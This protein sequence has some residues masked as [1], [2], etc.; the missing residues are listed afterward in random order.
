MVITLIILYKL[1]S[2]SFGDWITHNRIVEP[3]KMCTRQSRQVIWDMI[4][5]LFLTL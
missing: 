4:S 2:Q 5:T 1:L 3:E